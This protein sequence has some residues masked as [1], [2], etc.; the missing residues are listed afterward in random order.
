MSHIS[1]FDI[2][3]VPPALLLSVFRL[4]SFRRPQEASRH[5]HSF[6][7]IKWFL[8]PCLSLPS[9]CLWRAS[10]E[11]PVSFFLRS[12][13][14]ILSKR[15]TAYRLRGK[16]R[17]YLHHHPPCPHHLLWG[18]EKLEPSHDWI[19]TLTAHPTRDF[20]RKVMPKLRPCIALSRILTR[21]LV[22]LKHLIF[23]SWL[24]IISYQPTKGL[25]I[26]RFIKSSLCDMGILR[27]GCDANCALNML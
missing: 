13:L 4:L 18:V 12:S 23:V 6:F 1:K 16:L 25:T 22:V 19:L 14:G 17:D 24:P 9:T 3:L 27:S 2:H 5:I 8:I 15:S 21:S 11:A 20:K 7:R 10:S 26:W